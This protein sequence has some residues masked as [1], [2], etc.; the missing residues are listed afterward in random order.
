MRVL[1]DDP[2]RLSDPVTGE[3]VPVYKLPD[4]SFAPPTRE[5]MTLALLEI[6]HEAS[7]ASQFVFYFAGHGIAVQMAKRI[8]YLG[9]M[10]YTGR[11]PESTGYDMGQLFS[12][13]EKQVKSRHALLIVDACF[14][15]MAIRGRGAE[16][17]VLGV[18]ENWRKDARVILTAASEDQ[19]TYEFGGQ[20]VYTATL[21]DALGGGGDGVPHAD[22]GMDGGPPDGV[23]TDDEL[24]SYLRENV[25]K[26]CPS[27][28][29]GREGRACRHIEP[30]HYRGLD[31]DA[32]GQFLFVNR[33]T[34]AESE[35][36]P[37][38]TAS[39]G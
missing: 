9:L 14:G 19:E 26:K 35:T 17:P 2:A 29:F 31:D 27:A 36:Q 12:T 18:F 30:Q 25:R 5:N 4:G 23:V 16:A 32:E 3:P 37:N 38:A 28:G 1:A 13:I 39:G 6:G 11:N 7:E 20:S 22:V 8:G 15:G 21:L 34:N 33:T 24:A 10:G